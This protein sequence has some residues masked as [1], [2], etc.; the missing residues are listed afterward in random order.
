MTTIGKI[1]GIVLIMKTTHIYRLQKSLG[2]GSILIPIVRL[3]EVI[4]HMDGMLRPNPLSKKIAKEI[5]K[6]KIYD[7]GIIY[8]KRIKRPKLPSSHVYIVQQDGGDCHVKIGKANNVI[9]RI[10]ALQTG[11]PYKLNVV[12]TLSAKNDIDAMNIEKGIHER[13]HRHHISGEWFDK[14][15]IRKLI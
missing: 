14:D 7:L 9:K 1:N 10:K 12:K 6:D 4:I 5:V 13:F 2:L 8:S 15:I 11:S 3:A